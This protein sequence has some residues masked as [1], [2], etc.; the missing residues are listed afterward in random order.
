MYNKKERKRK[1]K[2]STKKTVKQYPQEYKIKAVELSEEIGNTRVSE[3][4]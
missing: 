3:E 2:M 1:R 4:L